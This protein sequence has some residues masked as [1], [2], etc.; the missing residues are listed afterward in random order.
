MNDDQQIMAMKKNVLVVIL[1]FTGLFING[2]GLAQDKDIEKAI[3]RAE[4]LM[5]INNF[6]GALQEFGTAIELGDQSAITHYQTGYCYF[7]LPELVD[8]IKGKEHFEKALSQMNEQIPL[9][10]YYYLGQLYHKNLEVDKALEMLNSFKSKA[11]RNNRLMAAIDPLIKTCR[12]AQTILNEYKSH[13]IVENMGAPV[14][15]AETEYNAVVSADETIMAFTR[16]QRDEK[17]A[18]EM[19]EEIFISNK[20]VKSNRWSVPAKISFETKFNVGTA[21]MK[22]DGETMLVFIG[23]INNTGNLYTVNKTKN[24]WSSPITMGKHVNSNYLETTASITPDGKIIYF[25]SNRPGG[26]GGLDIYKVEKDNAGNWGYAKNLGPEVNTPSD[27]DAPFIHP[28]MKTLFFASEGHNSMGGKDIFKT[29]IVGDK[30]TEPMNMGFPI[31]T[32]TDDNYFTLTADG[33]KGY[34]SSDRLG[35]EGGQDIYAFDMPEDEANIPLTLVKGRILDEETGKPVPTKIKV[36]DNSS[37]KKIDYVYNPNPET[38]NYLIIFPPG[39]NYD[40]II[41]SEKYMPYTINI[42]IPNQNYFYELYQEVTL[43][44]IKQFD[45]VVGQEISVKNVFYDTGNES[46]KVSVRKNNEAMLV[47]SDSV[48]LFDLMDAIIS[49]TD[50]V[51]FDYLLDL[52]YD[53]NPI[54]N[55]DFS[56]VEDEDMEYAKRTYYYD[57]SDTTHLEARVVDG[58]TIFSLPTLKVTEEDTKRK[59][60]KAEQVASFDE[61]LL[62]PVYKIYFDADKSELKKSYHDELKEII[63]A[64]ES[65]QMLGIEISGFA[66]ADGDAD[67]NRRLSNMRA[68]E[69]LDYFNHR[70]IVR[71]RIIAKGFGAT[72]NDNVSKEEGRRVE[73]KLVDLTNYTM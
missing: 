3:Y 5:R 57:E 49:S 17:N 67:Y 46:K 60:K 33:S 73:I 40:M 51:A 37:S 42:N 20:N 6:E 35:G 62:D 25:A 32:T 64:L 13:I 18:D 43:R 59:Q 47:K 54:D 38:G 53:V 71:R 63:T 4:K 39:K 24:G 65:H 10:I 56:K 70:G 11:S 68:I 1:V 14:N 12:N 28:D 41:E 52:M 34:I 69:V 31:N 48:D 45:V 8:K 44:A 72:E 21:G 7:N 2:I 36:I 61:D 29:Q 19:V 55:V 9:D 50:S 27:E 30:F 22:P 15:T 16:L 23:G 58:E 66:S 26:Y